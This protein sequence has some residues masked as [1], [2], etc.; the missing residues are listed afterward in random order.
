MN[1]TRI[2]AHGGAYMGRE[3]RRELTLALHITA[4]QK[5][6]EG[7]LFQWVRRPSVW[8][9]VVGHQQPDRF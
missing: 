4:L 2:V 3:R 1:A 6:V 9:R 8:A 5:L 7:V